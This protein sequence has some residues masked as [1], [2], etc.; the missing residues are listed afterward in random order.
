VSRSPLKTISILLVAV[1]ALSAT[2]RYLFSGRLFDAA[3]GSFRAPASY[4]FERLGAF[5]AI[6][7]QIGSISSLARENARLKEE[8]QKY[9]GERGEIE[10]LLEENEFLKKAAGIADTLSGPPVMAGIFSISLGPAGYEVLLNKGAPDG[11][12]AGDVV[13]SEARVLLGSVITAGERTSRVLF[14]TDPNFSVTARVLGSE[15]AG[16][17]K[18]DLKD[19]LRF[20][21]IVQDDKISDGDTVV[22]SGNDRFPA[23]L[24]IGTVRNVVADESS[25]FKKVAIEPAVNAGPIGRVL[26]IKNQ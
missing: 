5:R 18:G 1:V 26:V 2:D 21:L 17:A 19:G 15:T 11:I 13:I 23:G 3:R 16:I 6:V 14:V 9:S 25:V 10:A 22:S 12:G 7:G 4:L 24:I 20:E 8:N